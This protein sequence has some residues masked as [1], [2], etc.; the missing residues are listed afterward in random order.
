M[1]GSVWKMQPYTSWQITKWDRLD[2]LS[3]LSSKAVLRHTCVFVNLFHLSCLS[4]CIQY[5]LC[6][7]L[8]TLR[9]GL[10]PELKSS[11]PMPSAW[12]VSLLL[13]VTM[14][15]TITAI[16]K[17]MHAGYFIKKT[18]CFE[19]HYMK[20]NN[21]HEMILGSETKA[22]VSLF[23]SHGRNLIWTKGSIAPKPHILKHTCIQYTEYPEC[24]E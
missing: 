15:T 5:I 19:L 6:V 7:Y 23:V 22:K 20:C 1:I 9:Y 18:A 14:P 13:E 16:G 17:C 10:M 4:F 8:F 3:H 24:P 2:V 12:V 21:K 11:S